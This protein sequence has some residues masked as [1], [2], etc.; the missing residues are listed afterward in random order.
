MTF[1]A[2]LDDPPA[3]TFED[4]QGQWGGCYL[5]TRTHNDLVGGDMYTAERRDNL[6]RVHRAS[7]AALQREIVADY[8]AVPYSPLM[9]E[10]AAAAKE[11]AQ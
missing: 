4:L 7:L 1:T 10:L 3:I 6:S 5:I 9:A 2:D 8:K 11:K